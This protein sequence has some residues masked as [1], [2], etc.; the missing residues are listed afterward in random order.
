M[1]YATLY[2]LDGEMITTGVESGLRSDAAI[3][4]ARQIA[5]E[6][7]RSVI[8]EDRGTCRSYRITP[9]GYRWR[10]PFWWDGTEI[11]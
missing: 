10:V 2:D 6:R 3:Q 4:M 1:N 9:N 7:K 5:R 11:Q 8:V